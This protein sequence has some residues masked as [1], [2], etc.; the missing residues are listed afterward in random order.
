MNFPFEDRL[1]ENLEDAGDIDL[2]VEVH[3]HEV[4]TTEG[5]EFLDDAI[6]VL[7][8]PFTYSSPPVET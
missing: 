4:N 8:Q 1:V 7:D 3:P 2:L 6:R 5:S